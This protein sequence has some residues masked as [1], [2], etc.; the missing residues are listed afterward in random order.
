MHIRLSKFLNECFPSVSGGKG[1]YGFENCEVVSR[2]GI[3]PRVACGDGRVFLKTR[4]GTLFGY[5]KGPRSTLKTRAALPNPRV[6]EN[7]KKI[8]KS[9][10]F[11][12]LSKNS[13][14][15]I[16]KT[17][18]NSSGDF[19]L[20]LETI[21]KTFKHIYQS[22][23]KKKLGTFHF[24]HQS[25]SGINSNFSKSIQKGGLVLTFWLSKVL[26]FKKFLCWHVKKNILIF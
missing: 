15:L 20:F 6:Q 4:Y 11:L 23:Q 5:Q 24:F 26:L 16:N 7:F 18:N 19:K 17:F 13:L 2:G 9:I 1:F 25:K 14:I 10:F 3:F 21:I 12:K 8:I 22:S